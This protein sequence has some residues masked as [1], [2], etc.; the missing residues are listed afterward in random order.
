MGQ[1]LASSLTAGQV[2]S[3]PLTQ[4]HFEMD[5]RG[6]FVAYDICT[7]NSQLCLISEMAFV[8]L[9]VT[10]T[11][12]AG[13]L[14]TVTVAANAVSYSRYRRKNLRRFQSPIDEFSDILADF[15]VN[16][17]SVLPSAAH[18]DSIKP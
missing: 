17:N 5:D 8:A 14:V 1:R 18:P 11:K 7:G 10:A 3:Q 12:L 6:P 4:Q 9:F 15:D 2:A 13:I 16:G